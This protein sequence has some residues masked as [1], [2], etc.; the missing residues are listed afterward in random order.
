MARADLSLNGG[1]YKKLLNLESELGSREGLE[2]PHL[3]SLPLLKTRMQD[4]QPFQS[5]GAEGKKTVIT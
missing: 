4:S 3:N 2:L 1:L 5:I